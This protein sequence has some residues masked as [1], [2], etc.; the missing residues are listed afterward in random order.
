MV[1][2]QSK[3]ESLW[4]RTCWC[5]PSITD[6]FATFN[7]ESTIESYH[8]ECYCCLAF[9]WFIHQRW[10]WKNKV[11]SNRLSSK[12]ICLFEWMY[13]LYHKY[14]YWES[15]IDRADHRFMSSSNSTFRISWN[16]IC[17]DFVLTWKGERQR[18]N[19][20]IEYFLWYWYSL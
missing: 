6:S 14:S 4:Y 12:K 15:V 20:T 10:E 1:C 5:E 3:V 19:F 17:F 2:S 11:A 13:Y 18:S 8:G 9:S 16:N 7:I